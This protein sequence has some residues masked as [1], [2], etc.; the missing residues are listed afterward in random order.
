MPKIKIKRFDKG[1]DLP[2]RHTEHAAAFDLCARERVAIAP[3]TVAYI[4][5]NIAVETPKGHFMLL[6][7]RSSLH[8][9]GLMSINGIGIIDPDYSG[10]EDEVKGALYNFTDKEVAIEK[11]DRIMQAL[12]VK[13]EE[14]QWEEVSQMPNKTRG[15]FGST[16]HK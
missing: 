12:F 5:L 3:K 1:V 10:D 13:T 2:K 16:G 6:A 7:G 15:G 11:G 4:P 14:W 9:K 8:K